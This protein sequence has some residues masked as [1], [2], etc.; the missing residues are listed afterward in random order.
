MPRA[1][2]HLGPARLSAILLCAA[3]APLALP[4]RAAESAQPITVL[5]SNDGV[6]ACPTR[7]QLFAGLL[8]RTPKVRAANPGEPARTF[9]VRVHQGDRVVVGN[10]RAEDR[11]A[12][13]DMHEVSGETC[14]EVLE[15]LAL[16]IALSLDPD[17]SLAPYPLSPPPPPPPPASPHRLRDPSRRRSR[18]SR[19]SRRAR[20]S[21]RSPRRC[22]FS[23]RAPASR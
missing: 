10:L 22:A 17:A 2:A 3:A 18:R 12:A 6:A 21:R 15:A 19:R 8:A 16:T 9:D 7:E 11:R 23:S 1:C 5:L 20:P 13:T 14:R 4:A